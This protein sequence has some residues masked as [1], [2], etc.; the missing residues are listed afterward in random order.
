MQTLSWDKATCASALVVK[1]V[2][3]GGWEERGNQMSKGGEV[4][5]FHE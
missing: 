3:E 1:A 2:G 5:Q 4:D